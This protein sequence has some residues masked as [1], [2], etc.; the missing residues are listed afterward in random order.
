MIDWPKDLIHSVA[1]RRSVLFL[2]SG[3]S[4]N[5]IGDGGVRPPTW[6]KVLRLGIDKCQNP[7]KE[8]ND[9]LKKGDFLSCC[10]I[11]KSRLQD[12]WVPFLEENFLQPN[13]KPAEIHEAILK[14]DSSI[15]ATP[16]FDKIYDDFATAKTG[17]LLKTKY[18][19][20]DDIPRALR[21][22]GQQ[23]LILKVH[24][25]INTP[26]KVIFTREEYADARH[27]YSAFYRALDALFL[28]HTFIFIGCGMSDPDLNLLLEQYT[29]S[30]TSAP[31]HY[32]VL[33]GKTT[34]DYKALLRSNYNLKVLNYSA[35]S[36]HVELLESLRKLEDKV[37]EERDNLSDTRLW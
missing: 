36:G 1:R 15:V 26:D 37:N 20:D 29:R 9:L 19:Y 27:R 6:G 28:T 5:S 33:S 30:F 4:A 12:D 32:A 16:N 3:I 21:G 7:K 25:C 34:D 18:F 17:G 8:M 35:N 22:G 23:R 24:G 14:L 11:L 10:Q 31:P 2:G 13:F